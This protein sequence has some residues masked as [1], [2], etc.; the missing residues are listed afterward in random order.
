MLTGA[1]CVLAAVLAVSAALAETVIV[2]NNTK[3]L[4]GALGYLDHDASAQP[5]Q[6]R[7][8]QLVWVWLLATRRPAL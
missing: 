4:L 8:C 3:R 6:S 7:L 1:F 2:D 5:L